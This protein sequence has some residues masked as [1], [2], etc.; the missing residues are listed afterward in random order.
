MKLVKSE[1]KVVKTEKTEVKVNRRD[2][3]ERGNLVVKTAKTMKT[4]KI[5]KTVRIMKTKM[6]VVKRPKTPS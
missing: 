2:N 4:V 3:S 6:K 5:V 1:E